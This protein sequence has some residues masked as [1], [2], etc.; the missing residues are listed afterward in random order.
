MSSSWKISGGIDFRANKDTSVS[1]TMARIPCSWSDRISTT[2][3]GMLLAA[4]MPGSIQSIFITNLSVD[5]GFIPNFPRQQRVEG[6]CG[7]HIIQCNLIDHRMGMDFVAGAKADARNA[8]L[9]HPIGAVGR[10]IPFA[11]GGCLA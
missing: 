11:G 10:K 4:R 7:D 1:V 2:S 6:R 8:R 3:S 5:L 9:A